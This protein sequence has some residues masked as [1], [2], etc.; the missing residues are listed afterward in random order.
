M[1][2]IDKIAGPLPD[3]PRTSASS[4]LIARSLHRLPHLRIVIRTVAR[5]REQVR[6]VWPCQSA[7]YFAWSQNRKI[8]TIPYHLCRAKRPLAV[9]YSTGDLRAYSAYS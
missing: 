6:V 2:R 5:R 7:S 4:Y 3:R 1:A 8:R 9:S